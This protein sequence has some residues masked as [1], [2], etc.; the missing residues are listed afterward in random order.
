MFA[1]LGLIGNGQEWIVN[2]TLIS[3]EGGSF[4]NDSLGLQIEII[5]KDNARHILRASNSACY[6]I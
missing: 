5:C 3:F 1:Y 2:R 6:F 4:T